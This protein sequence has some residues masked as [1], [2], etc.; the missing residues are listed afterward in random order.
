MK[1]SVCYMLLILLCIACAHVNS[2]LGIQ[3]VYQY[4]VYPAKVK[5]KAPALSELLQVSSNYFTIHSYNDTILRGK[6]GTEITI[7]PACLYTEEKK[8]PMLPLKVELKELYCKSALLKEKA[9]TRSNGALLESDGSLYISV[10]DATG[11]TMLISCDE[12]VLVHIPRTVNPYMHYFEGNRDSA[13]GMNW[14]LSEFIKTVKKEP[15]FRDG[16]EW[17]GENPDFQP[18]SEIIQETEN[19]FFSLKKFGWIN[20]DKFYEDTSEKT[21]LVAEAQIPD[22]GKLFEGYTYIVFD[23][24]FSVMPA[25][26]DEDGSWKSSSLPTGAAIT[27]ISIQKSGELLYFGML[28]TQVDSDKKTI[29]LHRIDPLELQKVLELS[30]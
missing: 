30:L 18:P 8:S 28:K 15:E 3:Q 11:K 23:S 6:N 1:A 24:L 2:N 14:N 9:F 20:C 26:R 29:P 22:N 21:D 16:E 17:I 27:C 12:A 25:Y 5:E 13:G 7:R 4:P 10:A 19:Y